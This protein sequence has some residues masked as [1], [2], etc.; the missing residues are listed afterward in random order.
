MN[1]KG[2]FRIMLL[3]EKLYSKILRCP[4]VEEDSMRPIT[5]IRDLVID[6]AD[7][8][9]VAVEVTKGREMVISPMD[10]VS[11]GSVLKIR[12]KDDIVEV[13][14]LVRAKEVWDRRAQIFDQRVETEGGKALGRVVDFV[15]DGKFL[16]L[17]KLYVARVFL[18]L[19]RMESRI[20]AAK[21]IVEIL[22]DKII[23]KDDLAT[24]KEEAMVG[25]REEKVEMCPAG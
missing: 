11:W 9:V 13:Q 17:K 2:F 10:I 12:D 8:R 5:G 21:N 20:I 16:I 15:I 4:V 25:G 24:I 22:P 19:F 3:M 1:V 7:G 6:P 18:G 14:D 23:V